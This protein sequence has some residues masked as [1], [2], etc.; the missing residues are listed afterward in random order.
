MGRTPN[1]IT[2]VTPG[3]A[4]IVHAS[5]RPLTVGSSGVGVLPPIEIVAVP[6]TYAAPEGTGTSTLTGRARLEVTVN[7]VANVAVGTEPS[8]SDDTSTLAR[9]MPPSARELG[10]SKANNRSASVYRRARRRVRARRGGRPDRTCRERVDRSARVRSPSSPALARSREDF[11]R[12]LHVE[13]EHVLEGLDGDEAEDR[14]D[15]VERERRSVRRRTVGEEQ[16]VERDVAE[17][18]EVGDRADREQ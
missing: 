12:D 15:R 7:V 11:V 13:I 1:S 10:S 3:C 9:L 17:R 16:V 4:V 8:G 14:F 6:G 18:V 2:W 5:V